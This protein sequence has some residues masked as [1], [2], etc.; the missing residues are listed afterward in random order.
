MVPHERRAS[1]KKEVPIRTA[2]STA[3]SAHLHGRTVTSCRRHAVRLRRAASRRCGSGGYESFRRGSAAIDV[4]STVRSTATLSAIWSHG[5]SIFMRL[6]SLWYNLFRK[7]M[8]VEISRPP[9]R[10]RRGVLPFRSRYILILLL[11]C[12]DGRAWAWRRLS[13]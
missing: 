7:P 4:R 1:I 3:R 10:R 2:S 11:T 5:W 6:S 13:S 9:A 8:V 12:L